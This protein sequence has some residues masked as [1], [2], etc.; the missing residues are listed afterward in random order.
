MKSSFKI[1]S[2]SGI[3][4]ELHIS[5]LLLIIIIFA[6]AFFGI[7]TLYVAFLIIL[8]FVTVVIHEF[9]HSYVAKR[10]GVTVERIILLPIGGVSAMGEIPKDPSQELKIAVAGPLTNIIIAVFCLLGL[11]ITGGI[12]YLT[13]SSF[14]ISN[15]PTAD[16]NLFLSNFLGINLVLGI[17]N[18]LPAFPMDG[19]RVLRAFLARRMSY[20]KATKTA[21]T[22]GKQFAILMAI[23]GI[24]FNFILILIAI[25]IYIGADQEYKAIMVS[26]MLEGLSVKDIM[27]RK[28]STL[29]PDTPVSEALNIMFKQ[30]H[31]GYPVIDKDNL[32]GIIT[33]DD[34]SRVPEEKRNIP[35]K[36]IMSKKLVLASPDE[37]VFNTFEKISR[38]NIGRLP[39]TENEKLVGIISKT[40]IMKVLEMLDTKSTR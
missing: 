15:T 34:I 14:F 9:S 18:L 17:F 16:I 39:V 6:L 29:N 35:V 2:I 19:G 33:F 24:F 10:Y 5:F 11:I 3:P 23:F 22:I 8:L 7:F 40:D 26:S 20:V 21:A 27:T 38:N 1:F 37:P 36:D 28:V 25:F 4:V 31:M 13:V 12:G 32:V 30:R